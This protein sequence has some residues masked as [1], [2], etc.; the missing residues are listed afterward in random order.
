MFSQFLCIRAIA[1]GESGYSGNFLNLISEFGYKQSRSPI[2]P[3]SWRAL[4]NV[5]MGGLPV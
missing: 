5:E 3:V 4:R 2:T 1:V